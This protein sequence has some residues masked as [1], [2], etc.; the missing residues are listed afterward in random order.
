MLASRPR[1]SRRVKRPRPVQARAHLQCWRRRRA[2]N[3][4]TAHS[5][6]TSSSVLVFVLL[7]PRAAPFLSTHGSPSRLADELNSVHLSIE[8]GPG[9]DSEHGALIALGVPSSLVVVPGHQHGCHAV[10][11]GRPSGHGWSA[12]RCAGQRRTG[13]RRL[14]LAGRGRRQQQG[15]WPFPPRPSAATESR[16]KRSLPRAAE[17]SSGGSPTGGT[18][19]HN[20]PWL[21]KRA[22]ARPPRVGRGPR[23]PS[24]RPWTRRLASGACARGKD[25]ADCWPS[26]SRCDRLHKC[27]GRSEC[28]VVP[29]RSI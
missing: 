15:A 22:T 16:V 27:A 26:P 13:H 10:R 7:G 29:N 20:G 8:G 2:S 25:A 18:H 4:C 17:R 24:G 5:S 9:H 23:A 6:V 19:L 14:L 28:L 1:R 11:G 21:P 12:R 3:V